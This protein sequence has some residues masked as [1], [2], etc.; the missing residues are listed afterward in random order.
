MSQWHGGKGSLK[1]KGADD[2]KYRNEYDRIFGQRHSSGDQ[3]HSN[4]GQ[5]DGNTTQGSTRSNIQKT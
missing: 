3:R 5:P 1:R 2:D 4:T